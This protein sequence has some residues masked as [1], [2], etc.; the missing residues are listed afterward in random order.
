[1]SF[2]HWLYYLERH[3]FVD[4]LPTGFDQEVLAITT[5]PL[6]T[7]LGL[8]IRPFRDSTWRGVGVTLLL[9]VVTVQMHE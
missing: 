4:L 3:Y 2:S 7:D 8:F 6:Q 5:Q 1:M 9:L